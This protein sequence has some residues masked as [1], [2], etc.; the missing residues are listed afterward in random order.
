[1]DFKIHLNDREYRICDFGEGKCILVIFYAKDIDSLYD[2][3]SYYFLK[4]ER[5]ILVDIS[6]GWG[7]ELYSLSEVERK[8]LIEDVRLLADI[9]WLDEFTI[10]I[11]PEQ[12]VLCL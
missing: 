3:F 6:E 11:V 12:N 5:V 4:H 9:Y 7:K 8:T 2:Y 10:K 1:V